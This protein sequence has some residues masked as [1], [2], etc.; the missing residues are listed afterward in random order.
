MA[1]LAAATS[2]GVMVDAWEAAQPGWQR[3]L[4]VMRRLSV[5]RFRFWGYLQ[6]FQ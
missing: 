2:D 5:V 1:E 6:T 4:A 3:T